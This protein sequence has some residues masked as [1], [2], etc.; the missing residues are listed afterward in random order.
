MIMSAWHYF[1]VFFFF[2]LSKENVLYVKDI[3]SIYRYIFISVITWLKTVSPSRMWALCF[4]GPTKFDLI[5]TVSL[6]HCAC[7]MVG[8]Q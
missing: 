3:C 8:T 1:Q 2:F 6:W 7:H 5:I 4:E